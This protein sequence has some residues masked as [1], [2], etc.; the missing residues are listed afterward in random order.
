M[1]K[2]KLLIIVTAVI[3][4][5]AC[6]SGVSLAYYKTEDKSVNTI[7]TGIVDVKVHEEVEEMLKKNVGFQLQKDCVKSWV[8]LFVGL[9][10]GIEGDIYKTVRSDDDN[11]KLGTD[12]YYY[13]QQPVEYTKDGN[14]EYILFSSITANIGGGSDTVSGSYN[15]NLDI[16]V[17]VEAIQWNREDTNAEEAF[18]KNRK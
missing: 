2:R 16:V 3:L 4:V 6:C 18:Q 12:G 14:N 11:W 13:Y 17:Y 8:R 10:T 1:R 7:N 9:P 5:I 15:K